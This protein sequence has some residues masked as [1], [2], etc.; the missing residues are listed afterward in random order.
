METGPNSASASGSI[1]L[2]TDSNVA[3]ENIVKLNVKNASQYA[4]RIDGTYTGGVRDRLDE[5]VVETQIEGARR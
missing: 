5:I 3:Q 4:V 2:P 1:T